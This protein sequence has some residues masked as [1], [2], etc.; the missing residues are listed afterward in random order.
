MDETPIKAGHNKEKK[1]L[2]SGYIWS[3]YG[4]KKEVAFWYHESRGTKVIM[5]LLAKDF[6]GTLVTDGYE[7]YSNYTKDLSTV[8]HA[9]C[10]S[11]TR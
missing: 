11:H 1:K 6:K 3:L 7:A 4:K 8:E 2:K 9:M 5:K 10:W